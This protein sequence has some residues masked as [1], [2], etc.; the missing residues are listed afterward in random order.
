MLIAKQKDW[1]NKNPDW[2]VRPNTVLRNRRERRAY[3]QE[4]NRVVKEF[5]LGENIFLDQIEQP[6]FEYDF[7]YRQILDTWRKQIDWFEKHGK[8]KYL[9]FNK[10]YFKDKYQPQET[11]IAS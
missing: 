1:L 10:D 6:Y 5:K 2:F 8:L 11:L 9:E 7:L 3:Q 4:Y